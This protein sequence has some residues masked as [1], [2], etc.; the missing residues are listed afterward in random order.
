MGINCIFEQAL[1]GCRGLGRKWRVNF[2]VISLCV[3]NTEL[4]RLEVGDCEGLA[5]ESKLHVKP[6]AFV[7]YSTK[8]ITLTF[9]N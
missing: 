4:Q 8:R 1:R 9:E 7:F 3:E 5:K 6:V 2:G